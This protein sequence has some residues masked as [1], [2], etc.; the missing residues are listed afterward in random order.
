M[1]KIAII[2]FLMLIVQG[3]FA[4]YQ[5]KHYQKRAS[6]LSQKGLI[7]I[8]REK[9]IFQ[10]GNLTILVCDKQGRIVT[11]E[12]MEGLTVFSRFKPIKNIEGRFIE[13]IKE[14]YLKKNKYKIG[15]KA[16]LQAIEELENKVKA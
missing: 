7:G 11:A 2:A 14:E 8:G 10:A 13:H 9:G 16:M 4:F 12:K 15:K 3:L 5:V 6:Y 1:E